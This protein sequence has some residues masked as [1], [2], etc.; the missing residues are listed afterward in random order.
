M[1]DD[2]L[3]ARLSRLDPVGATAPVDPVSSPRAAE[4]MER[5]MQRSELP[6]VLDLPSRRRPGR[7][8]WVAAGAAAVAAA[9][10]AVVG[11]G[12]TGN[13]DDP[14]SLALSMPPSDV[15]ASCAGFQLEVLRN[16]AVAFAG[17]V[18]TVDSDQVTLDVARWYEGGDADRVTVALIDPQ[19]S[20]ALDGVDFRPGEH[21][22]VAARNGTVTGCGYSGPATPDLEAAYEEA[23]AG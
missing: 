10:A 4:L 6:P 20:A 2:Q 16:Q 7:A 23:F 5:A 19:S 11:L 9:V 1:N 8:V 21:Y 22:L 14:S 17:T 13:G 18:S 12:G 15:A 3:R